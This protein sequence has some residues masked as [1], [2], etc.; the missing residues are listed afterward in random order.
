[1]S[2]AKIAFLS[3]VVPGWHAALDVHTLTGF[4]ELRHLADTTLTKKPL[5]I[6]F[7]FL[8]DHRFSYCDI[9][10]LV[11]WCVAIGVRNITLYDIAGKLKCQKEQ[12]YGEI[13]Q[14]TPL[15]VR[16]YFMFMWDNYQNNDSEN[17]SSEMD[18]L[19][20]DIHL[21]LDKQKVVRSTYKNYVISAD[22]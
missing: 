15:E 1:M 16:T 13:S 12:L 4:T 19:N 11:T 8:E 5:H 17:Q 20:Q 3:N 14:W 10:K 9:A 2:V 18:L 21:S 6:A 22:T 7:A